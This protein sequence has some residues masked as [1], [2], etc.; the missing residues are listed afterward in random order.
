MRNK[1]KPEG[2][3]AEA[4]IVEECMLFCSKY[5]H[6]IETKFDQLERN[7]DGENDDY[8]GLSIF[9]PFG[10]P[11]GKAKSRHLSD[12]EWMQAQDYVLRNCDE[13]EAYLTYVIFHFNL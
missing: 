8:E 12:E 11:L 5:L 13:I 7:E 6:N 10:T 3:I 2:S 4:Y 9:A 1:S